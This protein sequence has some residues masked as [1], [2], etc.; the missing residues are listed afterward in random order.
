VKKDT[1][2]PGPRDKCDQLHAERGRI[3]QDRLPEREK[4]YFSF[5]QLAEIGCVA[6]GDRKRD[7]GRRSGVMADLEA[8]FRNGMFSVDGKSIVRARA[9]VGNYPDPTLTWDEVKYLKTQFDRRVLDDLEVPRAF[10]L[11]FLQDHSIPLPPG[12]FPEAIDESAT[13][14]AGVVQQEELAKPDTIPAKAPTENICAA[15]IKQI[16]QPVAQVGEVPALASPRIRNVNQDKVRVFAKRIIACVAANDCK[17]LNGKEMVGWL[18]QVMALEHMSASLKDRRA[19]ADEP[20][21]KA[22]RRAIGERVNGS[23]PHFS[24]EM[25]KKSG[26][27]I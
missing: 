11:R 12:W 17:P 1:G 14:A 7:G 2:Q 21:F 9:N 4:D 10:A 20:E 27:E 23:F 22:T 18:V 5:P 8:Y 13:T 19:I 3:E 25:W 24:L 15:P 6:G 16:I 26:R